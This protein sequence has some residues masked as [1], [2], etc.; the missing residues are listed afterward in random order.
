MCVYDRVGATEV[1][2]EAWRQF[3]P[4]LLIKEFY[5]NLESI[6]HLQEDVG[7]SETFATVDLPGWKP[8]SSLCLP[9]ILSALIS[10]LWEVVL[11]VMFFR[12]INIT[13]R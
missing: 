13:P 2:H 8:T 12:D 4:F 9:P 3:K 10:I 7:G 11:W 5:D 6:F 1:G